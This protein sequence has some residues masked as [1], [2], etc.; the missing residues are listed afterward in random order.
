MLRITTSRPHV[1]LPVPIDGLVDVLETGLFNSCLVLSTVAATV[2][3]IGLKLLT[4]L[5]LIALAIVLVAP[6]VFIF[7]EKFVVLVRPVVVIVTIAVTVLIEAIGSY[8]LSVLGLDNLE[9]PPLG[10]DLH[11]LNVFD[12]SKLLSVV[13]VSTKRVKVDFFAQTLVLAL[14]QLQDVDNLFTVEHFVVIHACN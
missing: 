3:L 1:I 13:L 14:H 9:V 12:C 2:V 8:L 5:W 11:S 10:E 7:I 6:I 4:Q